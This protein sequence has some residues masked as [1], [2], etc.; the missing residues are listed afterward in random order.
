ML[1]TDLLIVG[2]GP[3]GLA[4]AVE[5]GNLGAEVLLIERDNWLGGQLIKQTH[6]FFGSKKEFAGM[7]GF[8]IVDV[9]REQIADNPRI[10]TMLSATALG[11]YQEDNVL[12]MAYQ[13]SMPK[14]KAKTIVVATGAME[15][16]IPFENNDLPGV[17]GAGAVQTLMNV[18]GIKPGK[19]VLMVGAGNIGLIVAYQLMQADVK[20]EA[21]IEAQ[22]KIGGYLVHAS[23]IRRLGIPI[24]TRH[25]ILKA[26]GEKEVTKAVISAIDDQ[27]QPLPHTQKELTVDTICLAVGLSPLIE[28]IGQA[29]CDI[30]YTAALGGYVPMRNQKLAT[31]LDHIFIA[32]DAAG[33]EEATSAI[34]EGQL[35]GIAACEKLG[36]TID[37]KRLH[38]LQADLKELRSGPTGAHIRVGLKMVGRE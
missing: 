14:V 4:C 25:T 27:Y 22:A 17:Y 6:R 35:A 16:M 20:V 19:K 8:K 31:S 3:A 23:K 12:T 21:V 30:N 28:I 33:V 5:A 11:Y 38:K 13:G 26:K 1:K 37:E 9:F 2:A 34:L 32:G 15:K 18:Y 36:L 29:E 7:R 24:L 10:K